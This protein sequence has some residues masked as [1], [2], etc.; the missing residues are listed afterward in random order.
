MSPRIYTRK[1]DHDEALRRYAAG[2]SGPMLARLY[3][4]SVSAIYFQVSPKAQASHARAAEKIRA[5]GRCDDCGGPMNGLSRRTS[6]STRCRPCANRLAAT[7]VRE[8]EL[9]CSTCRQWK[10]DSEFWNDAAKS[11]QV[12]R[13][14][15][16]QCKV[17]GVVER[18]SHRERNREADN[19][20]ERE[21]KRRR[22]AAA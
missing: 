2:E 21:Y 16:K 7:S 11:N 9:Q 22:R 5:S 4:V 3:G 12:R 10:P 13:G 17:C 1:F 6:G 15:H 18:R 20:Y 8:T 14:K 19:A